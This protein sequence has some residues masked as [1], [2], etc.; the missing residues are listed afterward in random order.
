M[1]TAREVLGETVW[2]EDFRPATIRV[3]LSTEARGAREQ[4]ALARLFTDQ[5]FRLL[6]ER[7][8]IAYVVAVHASTQHL[9]ATLHETRSGA[10]H[11]SVTVRAVRR[12]VQPRAGDQDPDVIHV[13]ALPL[14]LPGIPAMMLAELFTP[15]EIDVFAR[16]VEPALELACEALGGTVARQLVENAPVR[17]QFRRSSISRR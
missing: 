1:R 4:D 6:A 17:E 12:R 11:G 8:R 3:R 14:A 10:E 13:L 15:D 2:S 16:K 5:A 7:E 9:H